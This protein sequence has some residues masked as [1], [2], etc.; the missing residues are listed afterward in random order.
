M[1]FIVSSGTLSFKLLSTKREFSLVSTPNIGGHFP[2]DDT[3]RKK[4]SI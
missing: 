3:L 4:N 2:A 1:G